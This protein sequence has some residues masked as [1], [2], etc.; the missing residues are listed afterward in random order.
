MSKP[1]KQL[2]VFV[3][4]DQFIIAS[5]P[6]LILRHKG[7]E[8]MSFH[9]PLDALEAAR[10]QAPDV[11]ISDAIMPRFSGVELAV[12]LQEQC[13]NCKV[14]LFSGQA[15]TAS[16]FAVTHA[17]GHHFEVLPKPVHPTGLLKK[18]AEMTGNLPG[19]PPGFDEIQAGLAADASTDADLELSGPV[20]ISI[21]PIQRAG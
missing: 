13:P 12:R 20:C 7:F 9:A 11:L 16:M 1:R 19:R 21:S 10:S 3:V 5:T 14:L 18:I 17:N 4:D 15:I 8:A 6:G 2:R